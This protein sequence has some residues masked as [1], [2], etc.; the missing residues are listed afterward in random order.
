M[1]NEYITP[2]MRTYQQLQA[3][4][5]TEGLSSAESVAI[6]YTHIASE[7]LNTTTMQVTETPTTG[8]YTA[9]RI[10]LAGV[11]G[12]GGEQRGMVGFTID[13][14]RMDADGITAPGARDRITEGSLSYR[15]MNWELD[16][17][18]LRWHVRCQKVGT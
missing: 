16:A 14:A 13:K 10:D 1:A 5:M 9:H 17:A 8:S 15:V 2:A 11:D 4:R 18:R 3:R 12:P 6:T 7:A